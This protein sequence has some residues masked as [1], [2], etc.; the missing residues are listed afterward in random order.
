MFIMA[1]D[2]K[3]SFSVYN[4]N[5]SIQ[6]DC[7]IMDVLRSVPVEELRVEVSYMFLPQII[8]IMEK[9]NDDSTEFERRNRSIYRT[10][11]GLLK[12]NGRKI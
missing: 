10:L 11:I 2:Y 12:K 6:N 1:K 8:K 7:F 3:L 9:Y 4:E 5:D